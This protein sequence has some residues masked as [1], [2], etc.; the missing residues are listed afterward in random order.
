MMKQR[1]RMLMRVKENLMKYAAYYSSWTISTTTENTGAFWGSTSINGLFIIPITQGK[2]YIIKKTF[3]IGNTLRAGFFVD[4]PITTNK[5]VYNYYT[6][7]DGVSL[8]LTSPSNCNYLTIRAHSG[9]AD[10]DVSEQLK[11]ILK[12]QEL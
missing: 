8:T 6:A 3:P 10:G 1:R 5:T 11:Q 4:L 2:T 9:G 7:E 12:V